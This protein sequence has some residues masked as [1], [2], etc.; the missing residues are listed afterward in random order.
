VKRL[1]AVVVAALVAAGSAHA[2]DATPIVVGPGN[3]TAP[4]VSQGS[5][6]YLDDAGGSLEVKVTT[7]ATGAIQ[8]ITSNGVDHGPPD[9]SA[10]VVAFTEPA[11]LR[12]LDLVAGT[13]RFVAAAGADRASLSGDLVAWEQPG[14]GG[15][16]VG[17]LTFSTGA[18]T[19]LAGA[20]DEHGPSAGGDWV[21]WIDGG[22]V[23]LRDAAGAV[24][25]A[26][27][28]GAL[29]VGLWHQ[30]GGATGVLA[31][32]VDDGA[33][34]TDLVV[35]DEAGLELGRLDR[36]GDQVNPH[37]W[38]DWVAFED[39]VTGTSQVALW[40]WSTGRVVVP[41]P[42]GAPQVLNDLDV[43]A[44]EVRLL[45][46]DARGGD[47]DL[48][49]FQAPLPLPEPPPAGQTRCD[50][51]LAPV[52]A[53]FAVTVDRSRSGGHD[54]GCDDEPGWHDG[55]GAHD[56][57]G[58]HDDDDDDGDHDDGDHEPGHSDHRHGHHE[59]VDR[60]RPHH[61]H[62]D[63][64][65]RQEARRHRLPGGQGRA[66]GALLLTLDAARP[67]LACVDAVDATAAWAA[68]GPVLVA[69]P[70]DLAQGSGHVE[71]RLTLDEGETWVAG[72]VLG[73]AGASLRVRLLA[74]DG[75]P[76]HGSAVVCQPGLPCT[77]SDGTPLTPPHGT[78]CGAGAGGLLSLALAALLFARPARRGTR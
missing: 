28:A 33:A 72:L 64:D 35:V 52:I 73:R 34:G 55:D 14:A 74:D 61:G 70:R 17:L 58:W 60:S 46:A 62:P 11:G 48:Y 29:E 32:T 57:D 44:G 7:L 71:R 45:W 65:R 21:A 4:A 16:D 36:P 10:A 66:F 24:T 15:R 50:D 19:L 38:G 78:G 63:D 40:E 25:T 6:A 13:Q 49:L 47:F 59:H 42:T 1:L 5:V 12:A 69:T 41:S 76:F 51:P 77:M 27:P 39:L 54:G 30:R 18:V 68:V 9:L 43:E 20:G 75:A 67:A 8:P 56:D 37:A 26:W 22:A 3:Q 2:A 53:D 23:R 31:I